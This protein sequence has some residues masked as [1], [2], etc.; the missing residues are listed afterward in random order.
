MAQ[1]PAGTSPSIII[2]AGQRLRFDPQGDGQAVLGPGPGAGTSYLL[3]PGNVVIGPF[4][5]DR[6]VYVSAV[7]ALTY[8]LENLAT[9]SA[10]VT[11]QAAA[12]AA[13]DLSSQSSADPLQQV[14]LPR[15]QAL[16]AGSVVQ[17]AAPKSV[18]TT[19]W[20]FG[21][22]SG[23]TT[24]TDGL[25]PQLT[26]TL[27][28]TTPGS[29]MWGAAPG[30]QSD[31]STSRAICTYSN[32]PNQNLIKQICSLSSMVAGQD[33]IVIWMILSHPNATSANSNGMLWQYG[34]TSDPAGTWGIQYRPAFACLDLKLQPV[35]GSF[36]ISQLRETAT[37]QGFENSNTRTAYAV[38]LTRSKTNPGWIHAV[39][40]K[41]SLAVEPADTS[42]PETRYSWIQE[43]ATGTALPGIPL[44]A[45]MTWMAQAGAN[46]NAPS[47]FMT[48][49]V[50]LCNFGVQRRFKVDTGIGRRICNDLYALNKAGTPLLFPQSA[51]A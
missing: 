16:R 27:A 17:A 38:Q 51:G 14:L 23:A 40:W 28:G 37:I 49:G 34:C 26:A 48:T 30:I 12:Q 29:A 36:T 33:Q 11:P 19:W 7:R 22:G 43:L 46:Q 35:G 3:G 20:P 25:N 4:N 5:S 15:K 50:N 21:E 31:G 13:A 18:L 44:T 6:L 9:V 8:A 42:T 39:L 41:R 1:I 24:V 45:S 32:S 2:P 47:Q 10:Q